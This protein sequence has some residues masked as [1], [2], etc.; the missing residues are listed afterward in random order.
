M[1]GQAIPSAEGAQLDVVPLLVPVS[2]RQQSTPVVEGAGDG[3]ELRRPSPASAPQE[4]GPGSDPPWGRAVP[5]A[6]LS[7]PQLVGSCSATPASTSE[8]QSLDAGF[9]RL[10]SSLLSRSA[11]ACFSSRGSVRVGGLPSF[12]PSWLV[13]LAGDRPASCPAGALAPFGAVVLL[14]GDHWVLALARPGPRP[15]AVLSAF[16]P[17]CFPFF[18]TLVRFFTVRALRWLARACWV[19]VSPLA[20]LFSF[21]LSFSPRFFISCGKCQ[22]AVSRS[23]PVL[24]AR[25][26][27]LRPAYFDSP[28]SVLPLA[29]PAP[30]PMSMEER[31]S[32]LEEKV[33]DLEST[34]RI[35]GTGLVALAAAAEDIAKSE[36]KEFWKLKSALPD[37]LWRDLEEPLRRG[38][39]DSSKVTAIFAELVQC[40]RAHDALVGGFPAGGAWGRERSIDIRFRPG[41]PGLRIHH[42][43]KSEIAP[44]LKALDPPAAVAIWVPLS[45]GEMKRRERKRARADS[46]A[47]AATTKNRAGNPGKGQGKKSRR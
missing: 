11:R 23:R 46:T 8:G 12:V 42:L 29:M 17:L 14:A 44:V 28:R 39:S 19:F 26:L 27:A 21:S 32:K 4:A 33:S 47:P 41:M 1:E 22:L 13:L 37:L 31:V 40:L 35:R 36:A 3:W 18:L 24:A 5:S 7:G 20:L 9:F 2:V 30:P 38:I 16:G 25:F 15:L 34:S 45:G 10:G 6:F 43:I